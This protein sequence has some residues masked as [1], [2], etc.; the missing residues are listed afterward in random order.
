MI[1]SYDY[2]IIGNSAAGIGCVEGIRK[3]DATGS[4][5]I[6]S[7]E[8]IHAY[9]RCMITHYI[10]GHI[11]EK[12][13]YF[14]KENFYDEW[15]VTPYL[16]RRAK[17][18]NRS[19]KTVRLDNGEEI[20]YKKLLLATGAAPAPYDVPGSS[21]DGVYFLRTIADSEAILNDVIEGGKAVILGG[22][23]VGMKA[24]DALNE[25]GMDVTIAI[26]SSQLLSQTMDRYGAKL[27]RDAVESNG[28]HV[29]TD[30]PVKE[31]L[32]DDHVTG[33]EFEGDEV[34]PANLVIL[35]KGVRPNTILAKTCG[36]D[37][38]YGILVDEYMKTS[39]DDIYAAG[40]AAEALDLIRGG[41]VVHA[42]WPNALEQGRIAG[43]NMAG[44]HIAYQG[45]IGMNSAEFFGVAAI[46]MGLCRSRDEDGLEVLICK[47]EEKRTYRKIVLQDNVIVGAVCI[48]NVECAGVFNGL[49]LNRTDISR[50]KELLLED[51]FDYA[52]LVGAGLD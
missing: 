30:S 36:I 24:A 17:K 22:G 38:D 31:I 50:V 11:D 20:Q 13:M 40:D 16:G 34:V 4:I 25:R 26:A 5:A 35:A 33:V 9:S 18:I 8:D 46:S 29:L 48:G 27:I 51:D 49:I 28:I 12:K 6:L 37:V 15:N 52:K 43:M 7:Y 10:S 45:G 1:N 44:S 42:I 32:G 23:L 2:I 41:K 19:S 3:V 21:L 39:D 14:R 47:D